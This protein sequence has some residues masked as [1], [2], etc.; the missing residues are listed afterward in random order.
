MR[1]HWHLGALAMLCL[2]QRRAQGTNFSGEGYLHNEAMDKY[3]GKDR[4]KEYP[5]AALVRNGGRPNL[6]RLN[7]ESDSVSKGYFT[8]E[9]MDSDDLGKGLVFDVEGGIEGKPIIYFPKHGQGNQQF[10]LVP[11]LLDEQ[12]LIM[13][14]GMCL[15]ANEDNYLEKSECSN[16]SGKKDPRQLFTWVNRSDYESGATSRRRR[17]LK[18]AESLREEPSRR[19]RPRERRG[20]SFSR[21]RDSGASSDFYSN[22]CDDT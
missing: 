8:I 12:F 16:L 22:F 3:V 20:R 19:D 2:P 9:S 18:R 17:P 13:V 7:M 10:H 6:L 21:S 4:S 5:R 1:L 11:N 15:R 14:G